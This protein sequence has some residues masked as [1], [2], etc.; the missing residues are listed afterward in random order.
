MELFLYIKGIYY[1]EFQSAVQ[2]PQQLAAVNE[3]S[4]NLVVVQS[5]E[6]KCISGS[7]V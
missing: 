6:A 3:K 1:N 5:S 7:F 4:K 2:L